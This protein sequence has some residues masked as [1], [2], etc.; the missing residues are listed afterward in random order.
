MPRSSHVVPVGEYDR[1]VGVIVNAL[2]SGEKKKAFFFFENHQYPETSLPVLGLG[3]GLGAKTCHFD[4]SLRRVTSTCHSDVSLRRVSPTASGKPLRL[5][6]SGL[7]S[8]TSTVRLSRTSSSVS[9][10]DKLLPFV[11]D[12]H[13]FCTK[14]PFLLQIQDTLES[15]CPRRVRY[16][17]A[18]SSE[19][20]YSRIHSVIICAFL[21][22]PYH[23]FRSHG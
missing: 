2:L 23:R 6:C 17:G 20:F 12:G 5:D 14:V 16:E 4:V 22:R 8:T 10:Y 15:L 3:L 21:S 13:S 9:K 7:Q 1:C 11:A 19:R 18:W